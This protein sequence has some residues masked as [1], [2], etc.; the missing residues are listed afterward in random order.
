MKNVNFFLSIIIIVIITV[1]CNNP[2]SKSGSDEIS[3]K[4]ESERH[5]I[6]STGV[7][8]PEPYS[9]DEV[10]RRIGMVTKLKKEYVEEYKRLHADSTPGVRDL[11]Q[12]YNMR[13]FSIFL[14]QLK[15]GNYYEFG[16]YEYIGDNYEEDMAKLDQ[17]PRNKE[18]LKMCDPMQKPIEGFDGWANMDLIYYNP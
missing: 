8:N 15:D 3:S 9:N 2:Q 6:K 18:W 1:S 16:Y 4:A 11:L 14:I 17:E 12:K 10:T 5:P 7:D 13:N